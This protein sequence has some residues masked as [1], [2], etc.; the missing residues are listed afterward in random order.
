M[1]FISFRG[2]IR[3]GFVS[4]VCDAF[5]KEK[6]PFIIDEE[7]QRGRDI[8][9]EIEKE[10]EKAEVLIPIICKDYATSVWC[11]DELVLIVKYHE[12]K[13][14]L[15]VLYHV[16]QK[17]VMSQKGCFE[18]A[19]DDLGNTYTEEVVNMW[20]IAFRKIA[21]FTPHLVRIDRHESEVVQNITRD[22]CKMLKRVC[23]L[24]T[25]GPHD[26]I[27]NI[28]AAPDRFSSQHGSGIPFV[29]E[30][31][32]EKIL[33]RMM[34]PGGMNSEAEFFIKEEA[35]RMPPAKRDFLASR[36]ADQVLQEDF[37]EMK[38]SSS[39]EDDEQDDDGHPLPKSMLVRLRTSLKT[40]IHGFSLGAS[41][42]QNADMLAKLKDSLSYLSRLGPCYGFH[43]E[44]KV[45]FDGLNEMLKQQEAELKAADNI[46]DKTS[47]YHMYKETAAAYLQEHSCRFQELCSEK[48]AQEEAET[49]LKEQQQ[50][51]E[52]QLT[53]IDAELQAARTSKVRLE[54]KMNLC[55]GAAALQKDKMRNCIYQL[56][57]LQPVLEEAENSEADVELTI[58]NLK[59]RIELLSFLL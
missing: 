59:N 57:E 8:K 16:N 2:K 4:F 56:K 52:N 25:N 40:V 54:H 26:V 12:T 29:N 31:P 34:T 41:V 50:A 14:I 35:S 49:H 20:R 42:L 36:L 22:V 23:S 13:H 28:P 19:F 47:L 15:P 45:I 24:D 21:E 7:F 39:S 10:I 53:H 18:Q 11:L 5:R 3:Y 55:R 37:D 51:L 44:E 46:L 58:E 17:D 33:A 9:K 30:Y 1:A 27:M 6:I 38:Y 48:M 43:C 32:K